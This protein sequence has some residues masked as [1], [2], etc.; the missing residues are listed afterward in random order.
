[1]KRITLLAITIFFFQGI[2][3]QDSR[4]T[5]HWTIVKLTDQDTGPDGLELTTEGIERFSYKF[6]KP[7]FLQR[8]TDTIIRRTSDTMKTRMTS[9]DSSRCRSRAAELANEL[10]FTHG[11]SLD[12]RNTMEAIMMHYKGAYIQFNPDGTYA[13]SFEAGKSIEGKYKVNKSIGKIT[14]EG[15]DNEK[16]FY[17]FENGQLI[18][19]TGDGQMEIKLKKQ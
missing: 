9:I 8:L 18:M 14:T 1:M 15:E 16:Y 10:K 7:I 11:D 17:S 5:G 2:Q 6:Y 4:L 13:M 12:I 19:R 3:A